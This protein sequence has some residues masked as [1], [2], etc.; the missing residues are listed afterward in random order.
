MNIDF[1]IS[2]IAI[3]SYI[4]GIVIVA[5]IPQRTKRLNTKIGSCLLPLERSSS[6]LYIIAIICCFIVIALLRFRSFS[7]FVTVILDITCLLGLNLSVK[8]ILYRRAGGVYEN[9]LITQGD[10]FYR[11]NIIAIPVLNY[12]KTTE[13]EEYAYKNTLK[14]VTD[15]G[16]ET[17]IGFANA[18]EK[19]ATLKIVKAWF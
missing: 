19:E 10:L 5:S 14:I 8:E 3:V 9:A 13:T 16:G 6:K 12:D 18:Q 11:E 4:V 7:I 15:K 17:W 1:I 2:V